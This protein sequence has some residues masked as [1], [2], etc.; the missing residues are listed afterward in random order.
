MQQSI[1]IKQSN[2]SPN[3]LKYTEN[4]IEKS[5]CAFVCSQG[6][7]LPPITNVDELTN[8]LKKFC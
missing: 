1:I 6:I 8:V 2:V 5:S 7:C 3:R 4:Q